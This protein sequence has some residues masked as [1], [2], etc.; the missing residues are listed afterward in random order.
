MVGKPQAPIPAEHPPKAKL[1]SRRGHEIFTADDVGNSLQGV[2]DADRELVGPVAVAIAQQHIP[3]LARWFL[4]DDAEEKIV[5]GLY[6][7]A[8]LN[9]QPAAGRFR[10]TPIAAG[11]VVPFAGNV[12]A[13]AG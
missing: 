1:T 2:V 3:T 7:F 4:L 11:A 13:G 12:F 10:Q 8:K 5:E 9:A 6:A